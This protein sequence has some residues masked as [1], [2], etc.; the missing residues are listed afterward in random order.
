MSTKIFQVS[1][2]QKKNMVYNVNHNLLQG[3]TDA[4]KNGQT[5]MAL[6]YL[7][8]IFENLNNEMLETEH[9]KTV[10]PEEVKTPKSRSVKPAESTAESD[11]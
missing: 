11:D 4:A 7:A 9:A 5:R 8:F 1:E 3:F 6:E 2:S 10:A